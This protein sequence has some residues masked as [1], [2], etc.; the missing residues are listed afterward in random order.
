MAT[1]CFRKKK[2]KKEESISEIKKALDTKDFQSERCVYL[3]LMI[4]KI[5]GAGTV[6]G[7]DVPIF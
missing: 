4:G 1:L 3:E 2:K 6:R 7:F 5:S